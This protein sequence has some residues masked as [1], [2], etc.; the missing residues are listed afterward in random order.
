MSFG[1]GHHETTAMML[2]LM[3]GFAYDGKRVLDVGCG[4][5]VLAERLAGSGKSVLL[6]ERWLVTSPRRSMTRKMTS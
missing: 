3:L 2:E 1:T 5:G 4:T 6:V